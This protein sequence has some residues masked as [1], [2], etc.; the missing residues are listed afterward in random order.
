MGLDSA[1]LWINVKITVWYSRECTKRRGH[2]LRRD[3]WK[4]LQEAYALRHKNTK[5]KHLKHS[6]DVK[7][8]LEGAEQICLSLKHMTYGLNYGAQSATVT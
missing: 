3:H 4:Q 5:V 2:L 1:T 8:Y 7:Y 6:I